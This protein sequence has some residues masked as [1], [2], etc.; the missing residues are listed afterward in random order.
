M[1]TQK[2]IDIIEEIIEEKLEEKLTDKL[3]GLPSKEEFYD[4]MDNLMGEL[5]AIREEH[6]TMAHRQSEHSDQLEDHESRILRLEKP[7]SS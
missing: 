6:I 3:K 7:T 1:L 4:S 2:D 5:K